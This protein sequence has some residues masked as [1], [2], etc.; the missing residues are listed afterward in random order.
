MYCYHNASQI[1]YSGNTSS[2]YT[3]KLPKNIYLPE[4]D[5]EVA[6]ASISFPDLISQVV[7]SE[8]T[9]YDLETR[10]PMI[11]NYKMFCKVLYDDGKSI[12]VKKDEKKRQR[13][14]R[15]YSVLPS[16]RW[17]YQIGF[18]R[19]GRDFQNPYKADMKFGLV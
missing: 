2:N 16:C 6:L 5:W 13:H 9:T 19:I 11:M 17:S 3:V 10:I 1:T 4:S 14:R 18:G 12:S 8:D 7:E 15:R